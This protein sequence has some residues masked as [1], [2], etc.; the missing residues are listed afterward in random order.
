[1]IQ[2]YLV[3]LVSG[4]QV[5]MRVSRRYMPRLKTSSEVATM[6]YL[7][8]HSTIPVPDVYA[9]DSNPYNRLGAE[10]ILMSKVSHSQRYE[11][12]GMT[13]MVLTGLWCTII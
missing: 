7:R 9:Y 4:R 10:Y 6:H 13:L 8:T 2:A 11:I 3:T 12:G 5:V 1:L